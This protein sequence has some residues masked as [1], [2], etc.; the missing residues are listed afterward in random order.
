MQTEKNTRSR[1][2][3]AMKLT[4][5]VSVAAFASVAFAAASSSAESTTPRTPGLVWGACPT[6][7]PAPQQCAEL[8]VPL[9]YRTPKSRNIKIEVSRIPAADPAKR[10]GVLMVNGG[11]PSSSLDV[12]TAF[13]PLL[14]QEIRDSYDV[15]AFDPRGILNPGRMS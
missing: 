14:A 10:K 9:D 15:V 8:T 3:I 6:G 4:G 1:K 7:A 11:G 5:I 13:G 2:R 12:P